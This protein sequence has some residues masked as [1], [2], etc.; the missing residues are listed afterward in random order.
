MAKMCGNALHAFVAAFIVTLLALSGA[1]AQSG[2][3][4]R[5]GLSLALL[6]M[7]SIALLLTH[8]IARLYPAFERDLAPIVVGAIIVME[9]VGPIAVQIG[10]RIAGDT[11]PEPEGSLEAPRAA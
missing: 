1:S 5:I 11:V 4:I 2:N 7:S 10:L 3:P 6:P 8:D 9:V